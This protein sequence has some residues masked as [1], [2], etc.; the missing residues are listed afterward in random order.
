MFWFHCQVYLGKT[1]CYLLLT[2]PLVVKFELPK[3][4]QE[5][6]CSSK[7]TIGNIIAASNTEAGLGQKLFSYDCWKQ[8]FNNID[9]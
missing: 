6:P 9:M 1:T 7:I 8:C 4:S 5:N 2:G 3:Q